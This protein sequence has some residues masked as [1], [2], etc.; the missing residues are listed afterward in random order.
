MASPLSLRVDVDFR[1]LIREA[2]NAGATLDDLADA[3]DDVEDTSKTAS[4]SAVRGLDDVDKASKTA[5]DGVDDMGSKFD[6]VGNLAQDVFSGDIAGA[7]QS[8][9]GA[10]TNVG[11]S[12]PGLGI[13]LG[14]IGTI[15]GLAFSA[16]QENAEKIEK[17]TSDM[18]DDMVESGSR[19]LSSTYLLSA[20]QDLI[21][22]PG[23][24]ADAK[25]Y[26]DLLGIDVPTAIG[27]L[28]GKSDDLI[29]VQDLIAQ[30]QRD[31]ANVEPYDRSNELLKG[32]KDA[33]ALARELDG[34]ST[35]LDTAGGK[36]K[37]F[38]DF[39]K[40]VDE[41]AGAVDTLNS[42]LAK[43]PPSTTV[44]VKVDDSAV[45]NYRPPTITI[46]ANLQIK[47]SAVWQ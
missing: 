40:S 29:V 10:L 14:G 25:K 7:A 33:N 26:A 39:K 3:F 27:A 21:N 45:K 46:P 44:K 24:L 47:N 41:S 5:G 12:I 31:I 1:E 23:Q 20:A 22:D 38:T 2:K 43:T 35:S 9:A 15:A 8:A 19:F 6:S 42:S 32:A 34:V 37:V 13:A 11:A 17:R 30:K 4:R 36:A 18:Y 28:I 16:W